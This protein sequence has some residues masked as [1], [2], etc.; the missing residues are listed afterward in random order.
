MSEFSVRWEIETGGD[1]FKGAARNALAVMQDKYSEA[2][3]FTVVDM[4]TGISTDVDLF[5]DKGD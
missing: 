3:Y 1:D 2:L 5:D 4:K